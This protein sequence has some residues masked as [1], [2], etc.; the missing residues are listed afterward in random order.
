MAFKGW[1]VLAIL[2]GDK[3]V[4]RRLVTRANSLVDGSSASKEHWA[5]LDWSTARINKG[6]SPSGNEGPYWKVDTNVNDP[7]WWRTTH[8]VYPRHWAGDELVMCE[9]LYMYAGAPGFA[10]YR[11]DES[12]CVKKWCG[13]KIRELHEWRWKTSTLSPR[14]M[15]SAMS[16]ATL[17]LVS[18]TPSIVQVD[19]DDEEALREGVMP[20]EITTPLEAFVK[21]WREIHGDDSWD[22]CTPTWRYEWKPNEGG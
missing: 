6:P 14:F 19:M 17:P 5:T 7:G 20:D 12:A 1:G 3:Y 10:A 15:P 16:R 2:R 18:V 8:R 11:A 21:V 22:D 4:T 13:P 9:G